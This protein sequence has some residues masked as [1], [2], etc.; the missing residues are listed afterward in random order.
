M[1]VCVI[2]T[3]YVGLVTGTV[4]ADL[5]NEVICIDADRKKIEGLRRGKMPIYEPGLEEMV[6]RNVEEDRL[7][8]STSI[9]EGVRPSRRQRSRKRRAA[10]MGPTVWLE[11]GPMP[12]R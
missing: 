10:R 8:F 3:G 4:F 9:R 6:L 7:F 1:N 11:L 2:G 12:M 5:G